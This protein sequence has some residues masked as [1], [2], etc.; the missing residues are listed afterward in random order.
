M[1]LQIDRHEIVSLV[2]RS[3]T[4]KSSLLRLLAGL[5]TPVS[6][7]ILIEGK[8]PESLWS[9]QTIA[10]LTQTPI[11]LPWLTVRQNME[12][13]KRILGQPNPEKVDEILSAINLRDAASKKPS[14]LSGGMLQR[15][16]LGTALAMEPHL[17]LLDEPYSA[18]DEV[19]RRLMINLTLRARDE[20]GCT[21]IA[22]THDILEAIELGDRVIA[23]TPEKRQLEEFE[24]H[25]NLNQLDKRT[26]IL[27][28]LEA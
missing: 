5:A 7:A 2:G 3:G 9:S 20:W 8:A 10:F 21:I 24:F 15:A 13:P 14:E 19:T 4:G 23:I 17:L 28:A 22:V 27:E 6:G 1:S 26:A 18:L 25:S 11:L 16:M 12:L